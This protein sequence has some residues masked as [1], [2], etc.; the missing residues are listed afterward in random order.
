MT[1]DRRNAPLE[2]IDPEANLTI[3]YTTIDLLQRHGPGGVIW[4]S[5]AYKTEEE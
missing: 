3:H 4:R 1:I 5:M 2:G